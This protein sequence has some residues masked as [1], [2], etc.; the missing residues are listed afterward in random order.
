MALADRLRARASA[1]RDWFFPPEAPV[2]EGVRRLVATVY[3][4]LDLERVSFH[5]GL[6]HLLNLV[7][8]QA[9]AIPAALSPRRI[10]IHVHPRYWDTAT[11]QGLGLLLHEAFHALQIQEMGPGLGVLRPFTILY[12][13]CAG[14]TGFLYHRHPMELDAYRVAG[15]RR[16]LFEKACL[17]DPGALMPVLAADGPETTLCLPAGGPVV[18][19]SEPS[20]WGRLAASTPLARW[21]AGRAGRFRGVPALLLAA[22]AWPLIALWLVN[23]T[24]AVAALWLAR[25]LVEAAGAVAAAL[26]WAL[27]ALVQ[28]F[29]RRI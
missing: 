3:P 4:T 1:V 11:V 23:W 22:A 8:S 27:A 16:S 19:S 5:R 15:R 14:G 12:L 9:M 20:F 13:A 10:R 2:P 6:P 26:L 18:P 25:L 21:I 24:L 7:D 28:P 17:A 29:G